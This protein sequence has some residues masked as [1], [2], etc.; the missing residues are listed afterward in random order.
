MSEYNPKAP[1]ELADTQ[2]Q[3]ESY[4]SDKSKSIAKNGGFS[5]AGATTDNTDAGPSFT[6]KESYN[7][8]PGE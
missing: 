6:N 3:R 5:E 2:L 4:E 7:S 1:N 8:V